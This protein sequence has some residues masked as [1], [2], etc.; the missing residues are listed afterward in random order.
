MQLRNTFFFLLAIISVGVIVECA[1]YTP[2]P[3]YDNTAS[4][5]GNKIYYFG[6]TNN[7]AAYNDFFFWD[8]ENAFKSNSTAFELEQS[9][10]DSIPSM[11]NPTY[12]V[13]GEN[14]STIFLFGGWVGE[15]NFILSQ[16]IYKINV[17]PGNTTWSLSNHVED[18]DIWPDARSS[19]AAVIDNQGRIYIW[20]GRMNVDRRMYVYD[21]INDV[22][23]NPSNSTV[24]RFNYTA[25]LLGDGRILYIGGSNYST[26]KPI[27]L[28][29]IL[30]Y[31]TE[32][33]QWSYETATSNSNK[34]PFRDGHTAVLSP[35]G[36]T[37]I[38]YGGLN[39]DSKTA[40]LLLDTKSFNF[41]YPRVNAGPNPV[42]AFHTG[43]LYKNY[44]I[45]SFGLRN[46]RASSDV[47]ILD[48]SNSSDY[49]WLAGPGYSPSD[50]SPNNPPS[51]PNTGFNVTNES[52]NTNT[53]TYSTKETSEKNPSKGTI[54][55]I[56][57][58]V[59]ASLFIL[60]GLAIVWYRR[61]RNLPTLPIFDQGHF[62]EMQE[63][64]MSN[65]HEKDHEEVKN[66]ASQ[67]SN[68]IVTDILL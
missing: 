13:G 54:I 59:F 50:S 56:T 48:I 47:N 36:R 1:E 31:D 52:N 63:I 4:L 41:S 49:K 6:G 28:T 46:G 14:N 10:D 5:I 58:G 57:L 25:T 12:V 65:Y 55:G 53:S 32:S 43:T 62:S 20:G 42:P 11:Y 68:R 66:D 44:M 38:I 29:Q 67:N 7:K 19:A 27:D 18:N 8:L 16:T 26:L 64:P 2:D 45:V 37:I 15:S 30:I 61:R 39:I 24:S 51:N 21:T 3:R 22:W 9:L 23:S 33:H 17:K 60:G 40:L 34:L 35:D